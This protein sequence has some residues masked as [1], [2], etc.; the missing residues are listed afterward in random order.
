MSSCWTALAGEA[1]DSFRCEIVGHMWGKHLATDG[2]VQRR[3]F[4][5]TR[6]VGQNSGGGEVSRFGKRKWGSPEPENLADVTK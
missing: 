4:Q 5:F 6:S 3:I 2:L 1:V